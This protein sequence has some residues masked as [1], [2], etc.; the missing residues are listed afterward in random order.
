MIYASPY[1]MRSWCQKCSRSHA[2]N[3]SEG[4]PESTQDGKHWKAINEQALYYYEAITTKHQQEDSTRLRTTISHLPSRAVTNRLSG[5]SV[6]HDDT[7][8]LE[9]FKLFSYSR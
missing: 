6:T 9:R 3:V 4:N 5:A 1:Q 8:R 2:R 7:T